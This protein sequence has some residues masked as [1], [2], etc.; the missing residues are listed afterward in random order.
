MIRHLSNDIYGFK[1]PN[2]GAVFLA[3]CQIHHRVSEKWILYKFSLIKS[4]FSGL[5]LPPN[6]LLKFLWRACLK[7]AY[8]VST[9]CEV[10]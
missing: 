2:N 10:E 1:K 4:G 6:L 8:L 5:Y 9:V 3:L 7:Q